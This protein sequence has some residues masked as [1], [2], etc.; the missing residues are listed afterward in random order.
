ML[1]LT[2]KECT[3]MSG[4]SGSLNFFKS[5]ASSLFLVSQYPFSPATCVSWAPGLLEIPRGVSWFCHPHSGLWMCPWGNPLSSPSSHSLILQSMGPNGCT[6]IYSNGPHKALSTALACAASS[7]QH[8][9][10]SFSSLVQSSHP[11]ASLLVWKS[12]LCHLWTP[13]TEPL[14]QLSELQFLSLKNGP[15]ST[16]LH[17][18]LCRWM[19]ERKQ[20]TQNRVCTQRAAG[21]VLAA[22][23]PIIFTVTTTLSN[24]YGLLYTCTCAISPTES[25]APSQMPVW[26]GGSKG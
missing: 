22:S 19:S 4:L 2:T 8:L 3:D 18:F 5:C 13:A 17:R 24:F 11:G 25:G 21:P 14:L 23:L 10:T 12:Q 20:S 15:S 9:G 6:R 1:F 26:G 16:C 7:L